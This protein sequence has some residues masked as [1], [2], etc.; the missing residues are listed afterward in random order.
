MR[1]AGIGEDGQGTG[2]GEAADTLRL[3]FLWRGPKGKPARQGAQLKGWDRE[4]AL[5][6]SA[7]RSIHS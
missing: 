7:V 3:L 6:C 4:V 5:A 2:E 1:P